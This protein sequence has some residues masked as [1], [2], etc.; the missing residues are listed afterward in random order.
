MNEDSP[1]NAL[2]SSF[3]ALPGS[4]PAATKQSLLR[5]TVH[6]KTFVGVAVGVDVA[7]GDGVALGSGVSVARRVLVVDGCG[8]M[9]CVAGVTQ[10]ERIRM[11]VMKRT[12]CL[13]MQDL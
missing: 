4:K 7:V 5:R 12:N 9:V 2:T 3:V 1:H 6:A 11:D 13:F 10:L 8:E